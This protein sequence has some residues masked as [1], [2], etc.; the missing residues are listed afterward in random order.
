MDS[1]TPTVAMATQ[2]LTT[3]AVLGFIATLS[4]VAGAL[5]GGSAYE[6]HLAG[7]WFFGM[8]DGLFGSIGSNHAHPPIYAVIAVYGGM[9]LLVRV[10][11]GL[12]RHL[13]VGAGQ[14]RDAQ[15]H[16]GDRE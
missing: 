3:T 10:W 7:S 12:L 14:H 13:G 6:T 11:L 15:Q 9:I 4:I 1:E 16:R 2:R 5:L 8:P